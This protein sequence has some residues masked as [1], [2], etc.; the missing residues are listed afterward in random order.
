MVPVGPESPGRDSL[1]S[2]LLLGGAL[3]ERSQNRKETYPQKKSFSPLTGPRQVILA[4]YDVSILKIAAYD[5]P[6]N[7]P[8]CRMMQQ[9]PKESRASTKSSSFVRRIRAQL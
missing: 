9:S 6:S 2:G 8:K 1:S 3:S 7:K 4:I 5:S